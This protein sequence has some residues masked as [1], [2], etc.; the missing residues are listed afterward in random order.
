MQARRASSSLY[1]GNCLKQKTPDE[2]QARRA[3][4]DLS[5]CNCHDQETPNETQAQ[6]AA[7]TLSQAIKLRAGLLAIFNVVM[8]FKKVKVKWFV[9]KQLI[10]KKLKYFGCRLSI[11]WIKNFTAERPSDRKC[12]SFCRKEKLK[13]EN[14]VDVHGNVLQYPQ[15]L[16]ELLSNPQHPDYREFCEN[17]RSYYSALS[18]AS[19]G[20]KVVDFHGAGPYVFRVHGQVCHKT[21]HLQQSTS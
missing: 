13:L 11:F 19:M 3:A 8:Q 20:A 9:T 6:R 4:K 15:F 17:I 18:S 16:R 5:Q 7:Q 1:L 2:T 12:T 10:L 14:P 21:S